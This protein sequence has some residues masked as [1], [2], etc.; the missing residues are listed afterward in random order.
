MTT[1]TNKNYYCSQKFWW[2]S[3]SPE[4]QY[5]SSCCSATHTKIDI[6]WLGKNP[7]QLFNQPVL[8]EERQ[9]ML[10]N[11]FVDSCESICWAPERAGLPSRRTTMNST[12]PTHTNINAT[13]EI[14]NI[15]LNSDCNLTCSYCNKEYS[16]AWLRDINDNGPYV[17]N[18]TRSIITPMDR[19]I[20]KLGRPA[21]NS[22]KN[23]QL[24]MS[25]I[26]KYKDV[27]RINISGGEPFLYNELPKLVS[28]YTGHIKI[29]TGLGVNSKRLVH[30]LELLPLDQVTI[31]IS[32]ENIGQLY[33]FNRYG[34][35]YRTFLDNLHIVKT[36][37]V[38]YKFSS[39]LSNLTIFGFGEFLE[40]YGDDCEELSNCMDPSYLCASIL[41]EKSKE[42][43][44]S[45]DYGKFNDVVKSTIMIDST[46]EQKTNLKT[47]INE[48]SKRRNLNLDI[49]PK[50]FINWINK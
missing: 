10:D 9:L 7:N 15:I 27:P 4:K 45:R 48:F 38:S 21:I 6:N 1:T 49:F 41:D 17:E 31:F 40:T 33:E 5:L 16:S 2:L 8:Q 13:P 50:H 22:N 37:G 20:L 39:V 23:Y 28:N 42:L 26:L 12:A 14:V 43:L 11:Q 24:I 36:S 3:V 47:Y 19:I 25:E 32:A 46:V 34:Q 44:V 35:S 18:E 30:I 29:Y